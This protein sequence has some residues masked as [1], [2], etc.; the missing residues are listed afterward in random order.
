MAADAKEITY[1]NITSRI[2]SIAALLA[3]ARMT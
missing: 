3:L 1:M 2:D